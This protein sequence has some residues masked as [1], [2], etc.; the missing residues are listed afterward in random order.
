MV[1][2]GSFR[3]AAVLVTTVV[4]GLLVQPTPSQAAAPAA[5]LRILLEGDSI[6]QGF[7]GDFTW[8]YRFYKEMT[9]Q[10][11]RF[12]LVGS[13][14]L[15]F[16]E[17]GYTTTQ[18]ADPHFDSDHFALVGS[19][20]LQHS[21]EVKDEV[22]Q[23][24]PDVIVVGLGINDL[25]NGR[26]P[27][28]AQQW[29]ARYIDQARQADPTI[30]IIVSPVLD[31]T[32]VTRPWLP[33]RIREFRTL[34]AQTVHQLSDDAD[35]PSSPITLADTDRGWSVPRYTYDNLHP[36]P[37]G[38]TLIAQRILEQF[39]LLGYLPQA[40]AI[41]RTTAW[42]RSARVTART[43]ARKVTLAWDSQSLSGVHIWMRRVHHKAR[44]LRGVHTG[45]TF[46]TPRLVRGARYQFRI[47]M[48]RARESTPYG[49]IVTVKVPRSQPPPAVAQVHVTTTGITW[50]RS[51]GAT[52]YVVT[53]RRGSSTTYVVKKVRGL[54]L[55]VTGVT[56]ASV[57]ATNKHGTSL[58]R[59]ARATA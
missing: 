50:T 43:A 49:P 19:T 33:A 55:S 25:R 29:L 6:T 4:A 40:P 59:T 32:D 53:Y 45:G 21:Y 30:R 22:T 47:Q 34:E 52:K 35:Y 14:H 56:V 48:I 20:L 39:H 8:R 28:V 54:S 1:P 44:V 5:P 18:Y 26:A 57:R 10:H 3:L 38:E 23:E 42:T 13:K 24:H 9:R 2:R 17:P 15:P 7:D 16:L 11:V 36:T 58:A 31:A 27:S 12:D 37:T 46:T 51:P 41:F